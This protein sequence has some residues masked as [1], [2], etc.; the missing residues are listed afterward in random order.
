MPMIPLGLK[1]T[2]DIDFREPFKVSIHL[3][4][5]YFSIRL[6]FTDISY[7]IYPM[8]RYCQKMCHH[9]FLNLNHKIPT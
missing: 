6:F 4:T 2:K 9:F 1:E 3:E 5:F 7:T 8:I